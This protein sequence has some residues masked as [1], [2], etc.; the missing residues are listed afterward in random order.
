MQCGNPLAGVTISPPQCGPC[1]DPNRPLTSVVALYLYDG[2]PALA[3]KAL[4][5]KNKRALA[6]PMG[7]LLYGGLAM[8]GEVDLVVPIPLHKSRLRQRGFNQASLLLSDIEARGTP[9]VDHR[10]LQRVRKTSSQA[11][12]SRQGRLRNVKGA[13][14]VKASEKEGLKGKRVLLVDDVLT[15]GSTLTACASALK[16]AGAASVSALVFARRDTM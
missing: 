2:A 5:Y 16:R 10:L 3:V 13:F 11:G 1:M 6:L 15:T 7:R 4:K 8:C 9:A 14:R 12:L